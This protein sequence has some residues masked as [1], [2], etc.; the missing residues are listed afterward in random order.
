[1]KAVSGIEHRA[2]RLPIEL[3]PSRATDKAAC[4]FPEAVG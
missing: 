2:S 4:G 3:G 1:L